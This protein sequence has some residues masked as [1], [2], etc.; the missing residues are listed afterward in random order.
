VLIQGVKSSFSHPHLFPEE[1]YRTLFLLFFFLP[2]K[3]II[4]W[5]DAPQDKLAFPPS[6]VLKRILYHFLD[7]LG[8]LCDNFLKMVSFYP[9]FSLL[10]SFEKGG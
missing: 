2:E 9:P 5:W 10:F 4:F 7:E 6:R 1:H 3:G 8:K